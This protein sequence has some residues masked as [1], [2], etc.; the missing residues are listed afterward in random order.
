MPKKKLKKMAYLVK[1]LGKLEASQRIIL[2]F[3]KLIAKYN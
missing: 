2:Y 1:K 3:F